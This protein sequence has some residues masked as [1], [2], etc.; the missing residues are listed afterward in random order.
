[1]SKLL[2]SNACKVR[3]LVTESVNVILLTVNA[4]ERSTDFDAINAFDSAN[5]Q[6]VV[7]YLIMRSADRVPANHLQT[8]S[9]IEQQVPKSRSGV[10]SLS[11]T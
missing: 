9:A 5:C 6:L 10:S 4:T 2:A 11:V 1:M 7:K 3:Q 8:S